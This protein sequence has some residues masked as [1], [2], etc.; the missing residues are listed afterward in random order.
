MKEEKTLK[1]S[2]LL[3]ISKNNEKKFELYVSPS[4]N[5][6]NSVAGS[7]T[8]P[9]K[10]GQLS[11]IFQT[12][13]F[14]TD[15]ENRNKESWKKYYLG[16]KNV[17]NEDSKKVLSGQEARNK[18]IEEIYL[19]LEKF[20]EDTWKGITK[21]TIGTWV[22]D[23][24]FEKTFDGLMLE[25]PIAL[26]ASKWIMKERK[27]K[28]DKDKIRKSRKDEESKGID[29]VYEVNEKEWLYFQIKTGDAEQGNNIR[30]RQ[31]NIPAI[32]NNIYHCEY[33]ANKNDISLKIYLDNK[34]LH[35]R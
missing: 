9:K 25:K 12:Y 11:D 35:E 5:F 18:S 28:F 24:L 26:F 14:E 10:V 17:Y 16:L 1:K 2:D 8:G 15:K 23:L 7:Q 3:K 6:L 27:D 21:D 20:M 29:Y 19:V 33:Q 22:D 13:I 4:I 34:L 32:G 30:K 31:K